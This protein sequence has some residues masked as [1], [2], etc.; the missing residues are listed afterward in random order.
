MKKPSQHAV[1][2][3]QRVL[4][5]GWLS[6]SASIFVA[7]ADPSQFPRPA[8]LEPDVRFWERIYSKVSTHGGLLHDDRH[9]EIVYEELNFPAGLSSRERSAL[10]DTVRA[11]YERIL[12]RLGSGTREDLSD[13]EARVLVLYPANVSDATLA[14]AAEH[15]RFQLGQADRFREGLVRSGAW[16]KHVEDTLKREGLPGELSALPHVESSFN[17][18]AYSKV[19][20]AGLWQ[21]MR[22]TGKRWLRVDA[23]VDER[24]D[25]YKS[26]LAAAQ[27][28]NINYTI[29]G[30]WPLA[31]TAWNHGAGGMRRA[32]DELGTDDIATIVRNYQGRTFGF[33]SRNFY[34]SF[35]AALEVDRNADQYFGRIDRQPH[36]DSR[37]V[38]LPNLMAA[39]ALEK[40][41]GTDRDTLRALNLALL[42]PVWTGRR[43]VPRGFELRVPAGVDPGRL[44]AHL[45]QAARDESAR[46]KTVTVGKGDTLDR[47]ATQYGLRTRELADYNQISARDVRAGMVLRI[48]APSSV[49]AT[50]SENSVSS[51]TRAE[52][53]A[54]SAEAQ[55]ATN[56]ETAVA[57]QKALPGVHVVAKGESVSAIARAHGITTATLLKLN[58]LSRPDLVR[59]GMTLR[60]SGDADAGPAQPSVPGAAAIVPLAPKT[61]LSASGASASEEPGT[62]RHEG[63]V[64]SADPSDYGVTDGLVVV[65]AAE[66]LGQ[67]AHWAGVSTA[68]L[69]ALNHLKTTDALTLGR[70]LKIELVGV[71]PSGFEARRL[72]Y[73]RGLEA[74]YFEKHRILGT[75]R[76]RLQ[77]GE[78]LWILTRRGQIPVWLL[79]QYNPD[80]DFT[81]VKIGTEVILPIF[82]AVDSEGVAKG[83]QGEGR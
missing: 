60:L 44:L 38:R 30:T 64:V 26:T 33:A 20:A 3:I 36:D 1:M 50:A 80:V 16:E 51:S 10:V 23:T 28:L 73:H 55:S 76:H 9:L 13:D 19:G 21:F 82:E 62:Y 8:A 70:R 40:T 45:N 67:L 32:K 25:P 65:Q 24:L 12:R 81:T 72:E 47:I 49:A 69:M 68:R 52:T 43:P 46:E 75:E 56:A 61:P 54:A 31:L 78:T 17:P 77:A 41:L 37:T 2:M 79:R 4:V 18:R 29:L 53:T 14:E 6:I 39:Q 58:E 71:D 34:V 27:F 22:G 7:H 74:A 11:H 59:P 15:V 42:D 48:P 57:P 83:S 35:L 66:T 63:V 5:A